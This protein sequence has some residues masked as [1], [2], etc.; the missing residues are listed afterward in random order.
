MSDII[1]K[2]ITLNDKGYL[3]IGKKEIHHRELYIIS[4]IDDPL[5][6]Q[7]MEIPD[8][9]HQGHLYTGEDGEAILHEYANEIGKSIT[10]KQANVL[11][12]TLTEI[13]VQEKFNALHKKAV[14]FKKR[15]SAEGDNWKEE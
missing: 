7:L 14:D 8:G 2:V 4:G 13:D 9:E 3:V 12:E 6:F 11:M 10:Q 5:E 1:D 15:K